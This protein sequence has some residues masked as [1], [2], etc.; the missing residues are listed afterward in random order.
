MIWHQEAQITEL[1]KSLNKG[2]LVQKEYE[3]NVIEIADRT[4]HRIKL[5][6]VSIKK[7]L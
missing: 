1:L 7:T 3:K 2:K 5:T 6:S 4:S